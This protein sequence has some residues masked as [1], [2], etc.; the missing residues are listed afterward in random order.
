MDLHRLE[1]VIHSL[2]RDH[3]IMIGEAYVDGEIRYYGSVTSPDH[4]YVASVSAS[5]R[6]VAAAQAAIEIDQHIE[7]EQ[8]LLRRLIEE[9][10]ERK[11]CN[12]LKC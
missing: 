9:I 11:R 2:Y 10:E 1:K 12:S 6:E 3:K 8:R 5:A 4:Y 7:Y